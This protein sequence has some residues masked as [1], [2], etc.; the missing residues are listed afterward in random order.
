MTTTLITAPTAISYVPVRAESNKAVRKLVEDEVIQTVNRAV[1]TW[2]Y[3]Q[4]G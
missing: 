3:A 4:E 2:L 1:N